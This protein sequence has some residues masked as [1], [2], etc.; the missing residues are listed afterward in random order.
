MQSLRGFFHNYPLPQIA[1]VYLFGSREKGVPRLQSDV[2]I[3]VVLKP[4]SH[5]STREIIK[6]S[7]EIDEKISPLES[8]V[9]ILNDLPV[10]IAHNILRHAKLILCTDEIADADFREHLVSEFFEMKPL[11]EEFYKSL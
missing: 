7:M 3:G 2:D 10:H 9:K 4:S 6:L 8:D 11:L 5:L 1:A